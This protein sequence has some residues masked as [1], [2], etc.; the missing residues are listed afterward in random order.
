M[1]CSLRARVVRRAGGARR[2]GRQRGGAPQSR[3][4]GVGCGSS[5]A[6][7]VRSQ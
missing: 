4:S 3:D 7:Y 5:R 1:R 2:G 6:R